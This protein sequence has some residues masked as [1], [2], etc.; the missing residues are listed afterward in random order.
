MASFTA[1]IAERSSS[2]LSAGMSCS[3]LKAS[4]TGFCKTSATGCS[5]LGALAAG[6]VAHS[7]GKG[8][9]DSRQAHRRDHDVVC[10]REPCPS[11][12]FLL[13]GLTVNR[14]CDI[15]VIAFVKDCVFHVL[16]VCGNLERD[17]GTEIRPLLVRREVPVSSEQHCWGSGL[18]NAVLFVVIHRSRSPFSHV[19]SNSLV[20]GS[21]LS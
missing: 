19:Q 1:L 17:I 10:V 5:A 4:G 15:P 9:V 2:R 8:V 20:L 11:G 12:P 18:F 6:C 16:N 7:D 3:S 13:E 21:R 14:Y